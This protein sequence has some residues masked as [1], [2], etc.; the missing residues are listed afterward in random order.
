MFKTICL[1]DLSLLI[2][3]LL[4]RRPGSAQALLASGA[5]P[6]EVTET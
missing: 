6:N 2:E 5:V 4:K 3:Q 1:V